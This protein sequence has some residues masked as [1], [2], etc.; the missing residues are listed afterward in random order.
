[1]RSSWYR[2]G[3]VDVCWLVAHRF[4]LEEARE[5]FRVAERR[6]GLKVILEC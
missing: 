4:L 2:R 5:A 3:L 1:M 6:E